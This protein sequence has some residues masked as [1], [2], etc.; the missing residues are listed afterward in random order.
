LWRQAT[1]IMAGCIS[2]F[3]VLAHSVVFFATHRFWIPLFIA[4]FSSCPFGFPF[5]R[6][7]RTEC[8]T[9]YSVVHLSRSEA[10]LLWTLQTFQLLCSPA[11]LKKLASLFSRSLTQ[12]SNERLAFFG[13]FEQFRLLFSFNL[14][15]F[16]CANPRVW[17]IRLFT[18][19][20]VFPV[21]TTSEQPFI[22]YLIFQKYTLCYH[23][24][25]ILSQLYQP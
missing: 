3:F 16:S 22:A 15:L 25:N 18:Q 21:S 17:M 6:P 23:R 14:W 7:S 8:Y 13:L 20:R 4:S 24:A 19:L 9:D 12:P 5:G 1:V 11:K 10:L 2:I